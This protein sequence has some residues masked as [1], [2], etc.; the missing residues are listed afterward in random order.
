M[1][2]NKISK[3]IASRAMPLLTGVDMWKKCIINARECGNF[4]L[5]LWVLSFF[6]DL[7]RKKWKRQRKWMFI[8]CSDHAPRPL[9]FLFLACR[10]LEFAVQFV[11]CSSIGIQVRD[12]LNVDSV[13]FRRSGVR[14]VARSTINRVSK[15]WWAGV[16]GLVRGVQGLVN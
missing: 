5:E 1:L 2:R 14:A 3:L 16:Q 8:D 15:D 6:T 13:M 4:P 12:Q 11:V 10:L 9:Q 7:I